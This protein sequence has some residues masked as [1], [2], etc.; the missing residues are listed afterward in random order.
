MFLEI[1]DFLATN[2]TML[3]AAAVTVGE[4]MVIGVNVYRKIKARK[5]EVTT[6]EVKPR[7]VASL[8]L[9]SANPVNLF[10]KP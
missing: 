1:L 8:L 7:S 5:T 6:M 4:L 3:T 9:W 2:K 10:R